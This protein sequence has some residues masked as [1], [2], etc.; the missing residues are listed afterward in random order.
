MGVTIHYR[1]RLRQAA[2]VQPFTAELE[3]ICRSSGWK[4][5]LLD[6]PDPE[7]G[8]E[9]FSG[10]TFQPH[11]ECE[12]VWM[13]FN[14]KGEL[15]HPFTY[16]PDDGSLP[17]SFTKTQFAGAATHMAICELFH[18]LE[19][20]WFEIFEVSDEADYWETGDE[21]MLR[22][23]LDYLTD[24]IHF[25]AGTYESLPESGQAELKL[26]DIAE[27]FRQRRKPPGAE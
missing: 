27:Q 17:W 5:R 25:I 7:P 10:I 14:Q 4:F 22:K 2:D 3:D 13:C 26:I 15:Y 16:R 9:P 12:T 23:K 20:K 19:G 8:D 11:A 18:Y 24:A 21:K 6:F 1:G